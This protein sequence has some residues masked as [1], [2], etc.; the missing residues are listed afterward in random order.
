[1]PRPPTLASRPAA[2]RRRALAAALLMM[3]TG[4][5]LAQAT[6]AVVIPPNAPQAAVIQSLVSQVQS[7][8]SARALVQGLKAGSLPAGVEGLVAEVAGGSVAGD[9]VRVLN[10]PSQCVPRPNRLD[11]AA[12]GAADAGGADVSGRVRRSVIGEVGAGRSATEGAGAPKSG[13]A[14]TPLPGK[15]TCEP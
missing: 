2:P 8:G 11:C 14:C 15:L 6:G 10:P 9:A 4:A 12:Q 3:A 1:M 5:S 7:A 13:P